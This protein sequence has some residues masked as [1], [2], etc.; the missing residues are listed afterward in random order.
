MLETPSII[1]K[2]FWAEQN[3]YDGVISSNTFDP[4]VDDAA[5]SRTITISDC[6][7]GTLI[8]R[9][10]ARAANDPVNNTGPLVAFEGTAITIDHTPP[11]VLSFST[12]LPAETNALPEIYT[13]T[14]S[15]PVTGVTGADFSNAGTSINCIFDPGTDSGDTRTVSITGCTNG[16]V[17]PRFAANGAADQSGTTGPATAETVATAITIDTVVPASFATAPRTSTNLSTVSLA[18]TASDTGTLATVNAYFSK[19]SSLT[20][21]EICG[22][23]TSTAGSGTVLCELPSVDAVDGTISTDGTYY[24]YTR[25]S[26]QAGNVE[27]AP[28]TADAQI[29]LDRV[30]PTVLSFTTDATVV[31]AATTLTYTLTFSESVTGVVP[32]DFS[33]TGNATG[34]TFSPGSDVGATRTVTLTGCGTGTVLPRFFAT[35][36]F[37][38]AGN[39]G[40]ATDAMAS[41]LITI[42]RARPTLGTFAVAGTEDV[43]L[44]FSPSTFT[45]TFADDRVLEPISVTIVSLP[46]S[47]VL[48]FG[49]LPVTAGQT[50]AYASLGGL[51]YVPT[52][53]ANGTYA[54]TVTVSDGVNSSSP[55]TTVSIALVPVVNTPTI[56]RIDPLDGAAEDANFT[57]TYAALVSAS[58]AV[59]RDGTLRFRVETIN[60][61]TLLKA[62]V[63]VTPGVTSIGPGESYVWTPAVNAYGLVNAF[64]VRAYDGTSVSPSPVQVQA[65][66][67][68]QACTSTA[69]TALGWNIR[70]FTATGEC[71]WVVPSGVTSV[72][73][74]M[75]GGG[76]SGGGGMYSGTWYTGGGGGGGGVAATSMLAATPGSSIRVTVGDAGGGS[77]FGANSVSGGGGGGLGFNDA[78]TNGPGGAGANGG[79]GGAGYGVAPGA[80]GVALSGQGT[81]GG[82][83]STSGF[84]GGAGGSAPGVTFGGSVTGY[85]RGGVGRGTA[86]AR[87]AIPNSGNGGDAAT[88]GS[89][90]VVIVHWATAAPTI[91]TVVDQGTNS[92]T[93]TGAI[94][95]TVA[96]ADTT[97]ASLTTSATSSN[98]TVIPT[99]NIVLG[100]SGA[101][102]T[103]TITPASGQSGTSTITLNV[104]DGATTTSTTFV[105]TVGDLVKPTSSGVITPTYTTNANLSV[106][107]TAVDVGGLASI[108]AYYST[109]GDLSSPTLCGTVVSA[110]TAG[111]ITCVVPAVQR[112]YY[113]FT[114]ATDAAGNIEDAPVIAD[115][116]V[117]YDTVAPTSIL[118]TVT[119]QT[120]TLAVANIGIAVT[121]AGQPG[122]GT[123]YY[124]T[125]STMSSPVSCGTW[126]S[127][128]SSVTNQ[129]CTLPATD[130]RYYL[131]S[132]AT[133]TAGNQEPVRT[134]SDTSVVL[135]RVAP[136]SA[137]QIAATLTNNRVVPVTYTASDTNTIVTVTAYYALATTL[138]SPVACGSVT[139]AATSGSIN[140]TL[141]NTNATYYV[142]TVAADLAT[143]T[144]V[145]PASGS[146]DDSIVLDVVAPAASTPDLISASDSGTSTTDNITRT[147]TPTFTVSPYEALA[148]TTISAT[149]PGATTVTCSAVAATC[150]LPTLEDGLWTVTVQQTDPAGNVAVVGGSLVVKIDNSAPVVTQ[151]AYSANSAGGTT[152]T[153]SFDEDVTGLATADFSAVGAATGWSVTSVTGSA[154]G[155]YT[156]TLTGSARGTI[157]PRL[158]ANAVTNVVSINGPTAAN[159]GATSTAQEP[160]LSVLPSISTSITGSGGVF[161]LT[162]NG[163]TWVTIPGGATTYQWQTSSDSGA[164]WVDYAGATTTTLAPTVGYKGYVF[165]FVA[166]TV[167]TL[168][169]SVVASPGK[170]FRWFTYSGAEQTWTVPAGVSSATVDLVGAKGGEYGGDPTYLDPDTAG[171]GGRVQGT[172]ALTPGATLR[173]NVGG[174]GLPGYY[175]S[176]YATSG[177]AG[178]FNGGGYSAG[179]CSSG[180]YRTGGSG[181]GATDIRTSTALGTRLLVAGG[182][183]GDGT[184]LSIYSGRSGDGGGLTGQSRWDGSSTGGTQVAGG[185]G[186]NGGSLGVGGSAAGCFGGG[187]GGGYYGGGAGST[188]YNGSGGSSYS[189]PVLASNVAHTQGYAGADGHGFAIISYALPG[190]A[191]VVTV[192][193]VSAPIVG[194]FPVLFSVSFDDTPVG[195]TTSDFATTGTATGWDVTGIVG[196]GLG[197]YTVTVSPNGAETE[198]TVG[199]KLLASA[200]TV[201]GVAAPAADMQSTSKVTIDLTGP[202]VS[203]LTT[204]SLTPTNATSIA[205]TLTLDS[206]S[207]GIVNGAFTNAG[208]ATG[209]TFV[210]SGSGATRTLTITTCSE[211]TLIPSF[212]TAAT[213]DLYSNPILVATYDGRT[214][215]IDRAAPSAP[216][217]PDLADASDLGQSASD[218]LTKQT[219]PT[220]SIGGLEADASAVITATKSGSTNV[221]CSI[222]ASGIVAGVGSCVLSGLV[223]GTWS[224]TARQTDYATTQGVAS[225]ALSI[226]IDTAAPTVAWTTVPASLVTGDVATYVVTFSEVVYGVAAA[227]FVNGSNATGCT[228][229]PGA[230]TGRR[231]RG[232]R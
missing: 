22:T 185:T 189:D 215:T 188:W 94:A 5:S 117:G 12:T 99:A 48:W 87:A 49:G 78:G 73:A 47:G 204:T 123:I 111:T 74:L 95:F 112:T 137:G 229:D 59:T 208:T 68:A 109:L 159:D 29:T 30:P 172:L 96:D 11:S 146:P 143:N 147:T 136:V 168:G 114:R 89:S 38:L 118:S 32:G 232:Q 66:V 231:G 33:N 91:S 203:S 200:V 206:S 45:S 64:T 193:R 18:Y 1:K 218:D 21:P 97:V 10:A 207:I 131:A 195:L 42:D 108:R 156:L 16:T 145:A 169:T 176:G 56:S 196:Y 98:T 163:G 209:C 152:F 174:G 75:V 88:V 9:L 2:I 133:D 50:I 158:T 36:A 15:E 157:I 151:F 141:P 100:G 201:G 177:Q 61:G 20:N 83:G 197:P 230:D 7:E 124:S 120:K 122:S 154:S 4:G 184:N 212:T 205:Y 40:P 92:N 93:A 119:L 63:A 104:T 72:Q 55:A 220:I 183:G 27:P 155:P 222:A 82:P 148:T 150:T 60:S 187:G 144:E 166:T 69:S 19:S 134:T 65:Q 128:A 81:N 39:L 8:P 211:G 79:G 44:F 76:G 80:G 135:D 140:C 192:D 129:T 186:T 37:D 107:Y 14:F 190:E 113:I 132:R 221:T 70:T 62:G 77:A 142:Y 17:R 106:A 115:D 101:N 181:G 138:A 126:T 191:K 225:S 178:G 167:N 223:Q 149:K 90:G 58:D 153:I 165:R 121:D 173:V 24:M 210:V 224:I 127:T 164:T 162:A 110:A 54:F 226:T 46:S 182:G 199:I 228:F 13:L 161:S 202:V 130:G 171:Y 67:A 51:S 41:P 116:T 52:Q 86:A 219:S 26:D 170:V 180:L 175:W 179:G 84:V 34:C 103:V 213:T 23:V 3:G 105:L 31:S 6:N 71:S 216:T 43:T 25:A 198:G 139:S 28:L 214:T 102:R 85:G 57:I 53:F 35:E 125:S 227:D 194:R 160:W 217:T